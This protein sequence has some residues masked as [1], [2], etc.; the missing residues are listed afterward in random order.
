MEIKNLILKKL[1]EKGEVRSSE[2]VKSTGYSRA[3]INRFFKEL[4]EEGT[5][6]LIGKANKA[7]YIPADEKLVKKEIKSVKKV[8]KLLNNLNLS[9]DDIFRN[10]KKNSGIT[11]DLKKNVSNILEYAFTE[12]L[13]N[14][15]EHSISEKIEI[16]IERRKDNVVF[17]IRDWGVG[18]FNNIMLKKNL[19]SEM[20]V[21]Q[22]LIKGKQT[23]AQEQHSGKGI[24]FT[25]KAGDILTI[26]S[27]RK[28]LIF[29]NL[30]DDIFIS[31]IKNTKGTKVI[32]S[33][34]L[35][36]TRDL[37]KIFSKYTDTNY[38]FSKTEID[39]KLY[40]EGINYVSRSQARRVLANLEEFKTIVFDFKDVD[41]VGQAFADEIFRVWK[42]KY[43]DINVIWRNANEN[44]L[45][46]INRALIRE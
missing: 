12:I 2:I 8:H 23:T 4:C 20:E 40:E 13:N 34:S 7:K 21:I 45:F 46:M 37:K 10:I 25:S 14:A 17:I 6:M 9:E 5:L 38:K 11:D 32:F 24:F 44:V 42:I 26:Q 3:Y 18:I 16:I 1:K 43:P 35:K 22:D 29:N 33:I 27:S 31:D 15:I 39:I 36:S 28:K 30:I 19:K 41:T